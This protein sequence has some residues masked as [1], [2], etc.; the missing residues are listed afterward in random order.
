MKHVHTYDSFLNEALA[1][2]TSKL[3]NINF[4][5]PPFDKPYQDEFQIS[6][7]KGVDKDAIEKA[8]KSEKGAARVKYEWT[9]DP[10]GSEVLLLKPGKDNSGLTFVFSAVDDFYGSHG[11]S[12]GWAL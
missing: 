1:F 5:L 6:F 10:H 9:T 8:I 4:I 7:D 11:A 3:K 2:N 12:M